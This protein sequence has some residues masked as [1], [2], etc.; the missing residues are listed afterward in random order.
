LAAR[1]KYE[2]QLMPLFRAGTALAPGGDI[3]VP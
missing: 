2:L 1:F 3:S